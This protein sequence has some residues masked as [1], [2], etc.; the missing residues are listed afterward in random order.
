MVLSLASDFS[1]SPQRSLFSLILK[2]AKRAFFLVALPVRT[3]TRGVNPFQLTP[4]FQLS[5]VVTSIYWTLILLFPSLILQAA[6]APAVA[7]SSSE[8]PTPALAR[9]PL[10]LDL[11]LHFAPAFSFLLDFFLFEKSYDPLAAG[12]GA[13]TMSTAFGVWYAVWVEYCASYNGTCA[14]YFILL[15]SNLYIDNSFFNSVPYPFL[16]LNPLPVRIV[17]YIIVTTIAFLSFR[18]INTLHWRLTSHGALVKEKAA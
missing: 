14:F 9:I 13:A 17:I 6:P 3:L 12:L 1:P 18:F 10:S 5:V 11:A 4:L 16:T 7:S 2:K 15:A 8:T